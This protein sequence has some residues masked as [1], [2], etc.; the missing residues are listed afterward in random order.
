MLETLLRTSQA[1]ELNEDDVK[2]VAAFCRQAARPDS[3]DLALLLLVLGLP[4]A[5]GKGLRTSFNLDLPGGATRSC[6]RSL[7]LGCGAGSFEWCSER[8]R[9]PSKARCPDGDAANRLLP[10]RPLSGNSARQERFSGP[11]SGRKGPRLDQKVEPSS[12]L[13]HGGSGSGEELA[14]N[15]SLLPKLREES[16]RGRGPRL[17][18]SAGAIRE[19]LQKLSNGRRGKAAKNKRSAR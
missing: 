16:G 2:A 7:C 12:A 15:A 4:G 6:S 13:F 14:L 18:G 3:R 17:A 9:R 8:N 10:D 5:V 11:T 1:A 19:A